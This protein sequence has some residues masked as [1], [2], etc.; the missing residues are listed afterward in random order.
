MRM[1]ELR[2]MPRVA[3]FVT[4][5]QMQPRVSLMS[6]K[7]MLVATKMKNLAATIWYP[8]MKYI[9]MQYTNVTTACS[10][11]PTACEKLLQCHRHICVRKPLTSKLQSP[12]SMGDFAFVVLVNRT[13]KWIKAC[14][15]TVLKS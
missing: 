3:V 7:T 14:I 4:M 5:A 1:V 13:C 9:R 10:H 6:M 11:S 2:R 12:R 15:H 8:A